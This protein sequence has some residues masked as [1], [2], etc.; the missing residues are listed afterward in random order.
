MV[1][2][3]DVDVCDEG[4]YGFEIVIVFDCCGCEFGGYVV[5]FGEYFQIEF[6]FD[7]WG[8][9]YLGQLFFVDYVNLQC[10]V[11]FLFVCFYF[12]VLGV[13]CLILD[14]MLRW[15][16][17]LFWVIVSWVCFCWIVCCGV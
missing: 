16:E 12:F 1:E 14:V 3:Y 9:Y 2:G 10:Y 13:V 7:C 11:L 4:V 15:C 6:Q 17:D 8:D 5:F